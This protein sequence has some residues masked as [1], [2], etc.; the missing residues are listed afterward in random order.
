MIAQAV[1]TV[2]FA[3]QLWRARWEGSNTIRSLQ[4]SHSLTLF[5]TWSSQKGQ[6]WIDFCEAKSLKRKMEAELVQPPAQADD[7]GSGTI[8]FDQF[9]SALSTMVLCKVCQG[10]SG[11]VHWPTL[12]G[13]M[14]VQ[15]VPP[16]K[17]FT[18]SLDGWMANRGRIFGYLGPLLADSHWNSSYCWGCMVVRLKH[19]WTAAGG[20]TCDRQNPGWSNH[21]FPRFI[22]M[23]F[24]S[25][26]DHMSTSWEILQLHMPRVWFL[27][28][29]RLTYQMAL[30]L[31]LNTSS[32]NSFT[33]LFYGGLFFLGIFSRF[34]VEGRCEEGRNEGRKEQQ[35]QQPTTPTNHNHNNN[36][37]Q[38]QPTTTTNNNN[39]HNHNHNHQPPTTTTTTTNQHQPTNQASNQPTKQPTNQPTN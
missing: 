2:V 14:A 17:W 6:I 30:Y 8:D 33:R 10:S 9:R 15:R 31:V 32:S 37:Q 38:Q 21:F 19:G 13:S 16:M 29:G 28:Q 5:D 3:R 35:Q 4:F 24:S 22:R 34:L 20:E 11:S 12:Q 39:N 25:K 1:V 7:N 36:N 26:P 18:T 23:L 27:M